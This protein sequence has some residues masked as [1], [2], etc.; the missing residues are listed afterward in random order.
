[1][2]DYWNN[3]IILLENQVKM[4]ERIQTCY[5][6]SVLVNCLVN[7]FSRMR[8]LH[9]TTG[10]SRIEL[11]DLQID[12]TLHSYL[13]TCLRHSWVRSR[14]LLGSVPPFRVFGFFKMLSMTS[15]CL[16]SDGFDLRWCITMNTYILL[17]NITL[18]GWN[19]RLK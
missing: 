6:E 8:L 11:N 15:C 19:T 17:D 18:R 3:Q 16:M 13:H 14:E 9:I 5:W 12:P 1:M 7:R 10:R 4:L 2:S